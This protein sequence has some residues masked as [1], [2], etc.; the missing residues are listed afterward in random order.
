MTLFL[1]YLL[2]QLDQETPGWEETSIILL[3][4]ASWHSS[5]VMKRRLAN[6][7]LPIIYSGPYSY[8]V[9][10]AESAFAA[11]KFGDL[12]PQ[13][14]PTGKKSLS[15]IADMVGKRLSDIPRSVAI[16]YWHHALQGHYGYLCYERL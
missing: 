1:R 11:L 10:P 13:R 4:N 12:N 8:S 5:E 9:A 7:K 2:R 14:L 15:H 3:D 16:S 6:M